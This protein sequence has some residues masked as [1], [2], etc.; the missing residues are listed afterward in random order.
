MYRRFI[1]TILHCVN[2]TYVYI[3]PTDDTNTYSTAVTHI[4]KPGF[5]KNFRNSVF[6]SSNN[7]KNEQIL[8]KLMLNRCQPLMLTSADSRSLLYDFGGKRI[9]WNSKKHTGNQTHRSW[10]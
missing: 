7:N 4:F 3:L 9:A 5:R 2:Y 8:V 10:S 1:N 6:N